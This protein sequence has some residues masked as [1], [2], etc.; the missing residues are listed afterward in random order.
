[1]MKA[2][3]PHQSRRLG[4]KLRQQ[5]RVALR[6][7]S[8][9]TIT[10]MRRPTVERS[11]EPGNTN[12]RNLWRNQTSRTLAE[13]GTFRALTLE[14]LAR[15]RYGGI[16]PGAKNLLSDLSR[17][18]LI[19]SRTS[20]PDRS[21]YVTLTRFGHRKLTAER[22]R[23]QPDQRLY[24]GFVKTREARHDAALYRLYHHELAAH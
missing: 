8:G 7:Q 2:S 1:M 16:C 17:K 11:I 4:P 10:R 24:H 13:I 22:E 19:R 6:R 12:I 5:L 20:Y 14:D 9:A 21:V 3:H 23:H 18:G 15:Q